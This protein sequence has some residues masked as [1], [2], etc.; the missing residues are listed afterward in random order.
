MLRGGG[1]CLT[2]KKTFLRKQKLL[3]STLNKKLLF[4]PFFGICFGKNKFLFKGGIEKKNLPPK[5]NF[6]TKRG[7]FFSKKKVTKRFVFENKYFWFCPQKAL[8]SRPPLPFQ[9]TLHWNTKNKYV[10]HECG[11]G[12]VVSVF[13]SFSISQPARNPIQLDQI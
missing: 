9:T 10:S 2:L 13:F 5:T 12:K 3:F 4:V 8:L 7:K 6:Q 11:P 1:S